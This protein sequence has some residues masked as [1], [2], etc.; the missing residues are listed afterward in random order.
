MLV[1]CII[2]S[3]VSSDWGSSCIRPLK[4][5]HS[6]LREHLR[7]FSRLTKKSNINF[8][9]VSIYVNRCNHF[10]NKLWHFVKDLSSLLTDLSILLTDLSIL[11]TDLRILSTDFSILSTDL[12]ILLNH[13][14]LGLYPMQWTQQGHSSHCQGQWDTTTEVCTIVKFD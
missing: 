6:V 11:L 12:S 8:L 10:V 13:T 3:I 4:I 9:I 2:A 7:K 1:L 5:L 14:R